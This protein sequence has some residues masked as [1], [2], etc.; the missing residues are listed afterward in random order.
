V[1]IRSIFY[2]TRTRYLSF[3]TGGA[4]TIGSDTEQEYEECLLKAS[5]I[6]QVLTGG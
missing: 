4:I 6:A 5:A 2:N 3:Q 1:V